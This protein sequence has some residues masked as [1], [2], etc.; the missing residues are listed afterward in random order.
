[1]EL[2]FKRAMEADA[3]DR[4]SCWSKLDWL[5][6]KWY[7]TPEEMLAFGRQCR[8]TKN[9]RAGIT[10]L[11]ADAHWRI[12]GMPG[13]DQNKYLASPEVWSDIQSVYDEYLKHHPEN[14]VARS[15]YATFCY[16]SRHWREAEV[17]YVALGDNLTQWSEFPYVPIKQLKQNRERNAR[18]VLGKEGKLT[19]PGW[20]FVRGQDEECE[21]YVNAPA[22]APHQD[23][24]GILGAEGSHVWGCSTDGIAYQL[25]LVNV[26]N[27]L[28]ND[29]P[30]KVL[31]AAR[32]V[33]A[34]ERGAQPRDVS[35]TLLAARPTKEYYVDAP[36][37]KPKQL[38]VKTVIIG[39]WLF[40]L[41]VAASKAELTGK[42]ASE[43]FDSFAYQPKAK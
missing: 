6:P 30:E 15:K 3:N 43:F 13:E 41:S 19:F 22:E 42:S 35:D 34:K 24:P 31:E 29:N 25:R 39:S 7:G 32:A 37:L 27:A 18:V 5:D 38:R 12:A 36:G 2:W 20:H 8:D 40:E 23:K 10:L 4:D 26:Q 11:V 16:L 9:S 17:Q 14:I 21:W 33:V 28:K 1:M